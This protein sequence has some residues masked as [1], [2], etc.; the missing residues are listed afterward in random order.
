MPPLFYPA[1]GLSGLALETSEF[2]CLYQLAEASFWAQG[3]NAQLGQQVGSE[4]AVTS[5]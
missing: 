3:T 2:Y 4:Y 5:V 1:L